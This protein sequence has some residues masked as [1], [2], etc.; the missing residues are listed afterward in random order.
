MG[1]TN[2][3]AQRVLVVEDADEIS[4][5]LKHLLQRAGLEVAIAKDGN[6]AVAYI[7]REPPVQVAVLDIL[8]PYASGFDLIDRIRKHPLWKDV[9]ILML[10]AKAQEKDIVQ[11]LK[12]GA[13]DYV[14][15]PFQPTEVVARIK[16]FTRGA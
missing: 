7:E 5:L 14:T 2:A 16:R 12:L 6:E 10:T 15:K 3:A 8:L 13:N 1:E 4:S 11:A 9:P